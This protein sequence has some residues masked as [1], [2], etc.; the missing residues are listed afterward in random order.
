MMKDYFLGV[1][2]GGTKLQLGIGNESGGLLYTHTEKVVR[3]AG[4]EGILQRLKD[5]VPFCIEKAEGLGGGIRGIGVGFGGPVEV[6]TGR[7]L[8]SVQVKGWEGCEIS[9]WFAGN[10]SLPV[11]V[12]ND[13]DAA[14]WGEYCCG[15]GRGTR[16][17]LYMNIGS[18][19]GGGLV[20]NGSL[21]TGQGYGAAEIGHTYVTDWTQGKAQQLELLCSGWSIEKRLRRPGY[22]EKDS[23]LVEMCGGDAGKLTCALLGEAARQG[24]AFALAEIDRVAQCLGLALSN[25]LCIMS[26][27]RIAL[28]GGV[29]NMGDILIEPV[30]AYVKKYEFLNSAGRYRIEACALGDAIVVVGAVLRIKDFLS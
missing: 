26:P 22:V 6:S 4:A 25:V 21:Y 24:D 27:E 2:I 20:I 14:C 23:L 18:G 11:A 13:S 12:I 28:G 16:Q 19:I 7:V 15:S 29:S 30:R 9:K 10:L 3:E 8:A 5:L 17:F 1:E